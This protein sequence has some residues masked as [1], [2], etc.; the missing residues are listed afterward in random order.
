MT[1]PERDDRNVYSGLPQQHRAGVPQHVRGN[2][3]VAQGWAL[4][5][6]GGDVLVQPPRD[7]VGGE[8]VSAAG[9][10]P[11]SVKLA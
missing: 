7:R 11:L 5:G 9:R 1:E 4:L 3:L 2:P 10:K 6:G 8:R